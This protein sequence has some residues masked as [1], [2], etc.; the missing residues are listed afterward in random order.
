MV[1]SPFRRRFTVCRCCSRFFSSLINLY[2]ACSSSM[3]HRHCGF[4]FQLFWTRFCG[5]GRIWLQ[6]CGF[7]YPPPPPPPNAPLPKPCKLLAAR[8]LPVTEMSSTPANFLPGQKLVCKR[9]PGHVQKWPLT[10][11]IY[12]PRQRRAKWRPQYACNTIFKAVPSESLGVFVHFSRR[13]DF[14][15]ILFLILNIYTLYLYD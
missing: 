3:L 15:K 12:P 9:A 13:L 10:L 6:F 2:L 1:V 14:E 5:F 7:C 11:E 8:K 4:G